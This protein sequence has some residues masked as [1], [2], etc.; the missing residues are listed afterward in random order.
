VSPSIG[1][2]GRKAYSTRGQVFDATVDGQVIIERSSTPFC[3]AARRLVD[4]G[5][6]GNADLVMKHAGSDVDALR[7]RIGVAARLMVREDRGAPQFVP[8]QQMPVALTR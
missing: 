1:A 6:D 3:D 8:Y 4:L 5:Y 7:A 2:D